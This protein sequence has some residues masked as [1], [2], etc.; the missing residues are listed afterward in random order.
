M[1]MGNV[2]GLYRHGQTLVDNA[3]R[4]KVPMQFFTT[5]IDDAADMGA[6]KKIYDRSGGSARNGFYFFP[7]ADDVPHP[8]VH[9][10]ENGHPEMIKRLTQM[11]AEFIERGAKSVRLPR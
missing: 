6:I 10:R 5:E 3:A 8:M 7:K 9:W 1:K 11:T 4:S 2:Y